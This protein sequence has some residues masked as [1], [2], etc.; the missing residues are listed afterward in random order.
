MPFYRFEGVEAYISSNKED[1]VDFIWRMFIYLRIGLITKCH[2]KIDELFDNWKISVWIEYISRFQFDQN[3]WA[4]FSQLKAW[5]YY[6][7]YSNY[8]TLIIEIVLIFQLLLQY[9]LSSK[10]R[11]LYHRENFSFLNDNL[12][13]EFM[14]RKKE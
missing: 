9:F 7:T 2:R 8:S 14:K 13:N 12:M 11:I 10:N 4:E 5:N 6:S 1:S 3:H